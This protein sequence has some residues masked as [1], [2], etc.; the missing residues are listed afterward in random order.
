MFPVAI[1][2][3]NDNC[4]GKVLLKPGVLVRSVRGVLQRSSF[5]ATVASWLKEIVTR[6]GQAVHGINA[7]F[8]L[9]TKSQLKSFWYKTI[10]E[11]NYLLA[12]GSKVCFSP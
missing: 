7:R 11:R 6:I 10:G 1:S 5:S 12:N 4:V 8:N 9:K 3:R 2:T